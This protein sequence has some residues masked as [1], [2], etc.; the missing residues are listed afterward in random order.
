[1]RKITILLLPLIILLAAVLRFYQIDVSPK[2]MYGDSLTLVLDAYSILKT[3]HDQKGEFLPLV[4][5]Q[6]GGRPG[7][8][9][10][11]TIPFVAVFGPTALVARMVSVLSGI[12]IVLL[13]YLLGKMLFS[14]EAGLAMAAVAAV[15]PWSLSLSRGAFETHFALF[16]ALAGFYFFL[17][18]LK[19]K[20]WFILFGLAFGLSIQT[21]YTYLLSIPL[22]TVLLLFWSRRFPAVA[23]AIIAASAVLSVYLMVSRGSQDRF[24]NINIFALP[25]NGLPGDLDADILGTIAA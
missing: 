18:G 12:G 6:G 15:N 9:I 17:K 1:L 11:A 4:F 13:L 8:Y 25:T 2:A 19:N 14:K 24:G 7:G 10:Y 3:G 23:L 22:F 5:S 21:Y 20:Y 16:L